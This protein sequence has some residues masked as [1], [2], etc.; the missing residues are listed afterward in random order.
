MFRKSGWFPALIAGT[1]ISLGACSPGPAQDAGAAAS[2]AT[3][4]S[5][6]AQKASFDMKELM[7]HVIDHNADGIW[8]HQ[9]WVVDENGER[10]LFPTDEAGWMATENSAATLA[11]ASNLLLVSARDGLPAEDPALWTD[12]AHKLQAASVR[13]L[14]AAEARD[15]EAFFNAGGDIY[16]VCR[17][18]H[19]R[20][21][22]GETR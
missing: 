18:C 9:G 1:A 10:D 4:I 19:Q 5:P 7:G 20:F 16:V 2:A 6:E 8:L 11:E 12:F 3:T 22:L 14:E 21:I 17:D 15:K 13:A